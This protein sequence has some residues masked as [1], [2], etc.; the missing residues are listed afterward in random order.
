MSSNTTVATRRL[1]HVK[2]TLS[3]VSSAIGTLSGDPDDTFLLRQYE[4]QLIDL[5]KELSKTRSGLLTLELGELTS[6]SRKGSLRLFSRGQEETF[7]LRFLSTGSS[8]AASDGKGV[9]LPKL[10]VPT[11]DGNILNW[12]SFWEQFRVS[13]H[14]RST[15]SDS[16]KLVYLQHSLKY[17]SAKSIIEG[18]SRSGDN[19]LEAVECLQVRFGR[20]RLIYQAQVRMISETPD[21]KDGTSKE[22]RRLHNTAQQHLRALKVRASWFVYHLPIGAQIGYEHHV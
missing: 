21:L 6:I 8:P 10:D 19:Y 14:D 5:K 13:V 4:E 22:L 15:L 18:L 1:A 9:K 2:K 11:F 7:A 20:P 17:G 3:N 16:E 12:R